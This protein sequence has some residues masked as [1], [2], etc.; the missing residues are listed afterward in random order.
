VIGK[1]LQAA[2]VPGGHSQLGPPKNPGT[3]IEALHKQAASRGLV[4]DSRQ[5]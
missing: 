3:F 2:R 1:P 5:A 4:A